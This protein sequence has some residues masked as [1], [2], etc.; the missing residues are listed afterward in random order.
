MQNKVMQNRKV[1]ICIVLGILSLYLSDRFLCKRIVFIPGARVYAKQVILRR[2]QV[3]YNYFS[4]RLFPLL[5][6]SY[7]DLD[8][9]IMRKPDRGF[10][11]EIMLQKDSLLFYP[12]EC[13]TPES[14]ELNFLEMCERRY[15]IEPFSIDVAN[16]W[17]V[18][19][20]D[21]TEEIV[22][23]YG[24]DVAHSKFYDDNRE[25]RDEY[26]S[27]QNWFDWGGYFLYAVP[28]GRKT[29]LW[30]L[31]RLPRKF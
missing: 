12:I 3:I 26:V 8:Y 28:S 6:G 2:E 31:F 20:S 24:C 17:V 7:N 19:N 5:L 29:H 15:K 23:K 1:L 4:P 30:S 14:S 9:V 21:G 25:L 18:T 16:K 22:M 27:I 10:F 11:K 13:F